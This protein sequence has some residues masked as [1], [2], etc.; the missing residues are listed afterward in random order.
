M[1]KIESFEKTLMLGKIEG[2]RGRGQQRMRLLGGITDSMDMN[3]SKLQELVMDRESW[4]AAVHGVAKNQTWLSNCTELN[5]LMQLIIYIHLVA[6]SWQTHYWILKLVTWLW[7]WIEF[8]VI[9]FFFVIFDWTYC[10]RNIKASVYVLVV[11]NG[12]CQLNQSWE[13][14]PLLTFPSVCLEGVESCRLWSPGSHVNKL[15]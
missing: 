1:Q 5:W 3:L 2:R 11:V 14:L 8:N 7:E 13:C 10:Y 15:S 4:Y 9:L 12:I 6:Q